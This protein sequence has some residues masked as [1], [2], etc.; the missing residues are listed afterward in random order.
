MEPDQKFAENMLNQVLECINATVENKS[1][2]VMSVGKI[3]VV[4][5]GQSNRTELTITIVCEPNV[6][7]GTLYPCADHFPT[8]SVVE[9]LAHFE[10]L[11][12]GQT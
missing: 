8:S 3:G 2:R 1:K 12:N 9:Q 11:K 6:W 7:G 4:P 10:E 5:P